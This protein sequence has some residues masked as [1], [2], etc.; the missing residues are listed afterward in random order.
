MKIYRDIKEFQPVNKAVVTIGAFDGV[1][2]GHK[3]ILNRLTELS[4]LVN[5]ESVL[6]T[7]WPHPRFVLKKDAEPIGLLNTLEEKIHLLDTYNI[8]HLLILNFNEEFS[9]LTAD[10]FIENILIKSIGTRYLVLGYD[11]RF[12]NNRE[13]SIDYLNANK[14]RFEIESIEIPKQEI[15]SLAISSTLIR[16][17]LLNGDSTVANQNLGYPY[18]LRGFVIEGNKLGRTIGFPTAN[19][20]I[21]DQD[22]LIPKNGVY[23]VYA[24]I[25]G[26]RYK[27]MLNIGVRP[28]INN[29]K[30]R[31]IEVHI[32]DFNQD[33]YGKT[34]R[35]ELITYIRDEVKFSGIDTLILQLKQ[36]EIETRAI[37]K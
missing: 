23:A 35:L 14:E 26:E 24:Y 27:G 2:I 31:T 18:L 16:K 19:I 11:H 9:K 5:G 17:A 25:E 28:T 8:D 3:K 36:D 7:F 15:E 22:K 1:H 30:R 10:A 6:I 4:S 21:E 29:D 12:G 37:L 33:I 20:F 13:G 34:V 32:F